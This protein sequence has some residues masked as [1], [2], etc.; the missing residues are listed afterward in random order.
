[1]PEL[2]V[3]IIIPALNEESALK[4]TLIAIQ[5][6]IPRSISYEI[7]VVD[8]DSDDATPR[9]A[10]ENGAK[11]V[12]TP[13]LTISYSRNLGVKKSS[14]KILIFLD[15]DVLVTTEWSQSIGDTIQ[16]LYHSP[17]VITGSRVT[18]PNKEQWHNKYWF[19]RFHEYEAPYINSGHLITSRIL[20]KKIGGFSKHLKTSE[21]HDFCM[22]AKAFGAQIINN[23]SLHVIHIGYPTSLRTFFNRERWHGGEDIKTWEAFKR[24]ILAWI[25]ASNLLTLSFS[26]FMTIYFFEILFICIYPIVMGLISILLTLRKY[27]FRNLKYVINT[28]IIFYIYISGRSMSIIDRII[29]KYHHKKEKN[30]P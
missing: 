30:T 22:R 7:V 10:L 1:M 9:I 6:N 15:A 14:G 24:S 18:P 8:N 19:Y 12:S 25:A 13:P 2:D 11:L 5:E 27:K 17:L 20:F 23:R 26:I 29:K 4:K 16:K 3:S 21:D 28:S